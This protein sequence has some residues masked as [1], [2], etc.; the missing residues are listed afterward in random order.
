MLGQVRPLDNRQAAVTICRNTDHD[1]N[2]ITESAAVWIGLAMKRFK[3]FA[4]LTPCAAPRDHLRSQLT[5]PG[6]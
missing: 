3:V 6:W 2:V 1:V 4:A 5:Q